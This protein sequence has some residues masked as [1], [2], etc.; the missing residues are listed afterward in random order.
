MSNSSLLFQLMNIPFTQLWLNV[1]PVVSGILCRVLMN[2]QH[3]SSLPQSLLHFLS[4]HKVS[5]YFKS[6]QQQQ[7]PIMCKAL[8]CLR[9]HS[10]PLILQYNDSFLLRFSL[11]PLKTDKFFNKICTN[12]LIFCS[13]ISCNEAPFICKL[14]KVTALPLELLEKFLHWRLSTK[15]PS[16]TIT[17]DA[18]AH[19]PCSHQRTEAV[20]Q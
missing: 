8:N 2:A 7:P 11:I 3:C 4:I 18:C 19:I 14:R 12:P 20:R 16:L 1:T 5:S 17:T 15:R 9:A 13:L 6:Q 10:F